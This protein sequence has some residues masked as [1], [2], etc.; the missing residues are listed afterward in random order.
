MDS[1]DALS[2]STATQP[3]AKGMSGLTTEEFSKIIF[4]ELSNQDPL[5]PNDTS[6]L[7]EQISTL[8]SIQS[9]TDLSDRLKSLVQ[10]NQFAA[11]TTLL[12][13]RVSGVSE[14]NE[15]VQGTVRGVSNTKEGPVV[16]LDTGE[17][18]AMS[19]LDEVVEAA[20]ND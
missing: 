4:T 14:L 12:G 16:T 3:R 6:A 1:I 5:S 18:I 10:Q 7:L 19:S 8:R 11:G 9:D 2:A 20:S 13:R 15:R 17:R